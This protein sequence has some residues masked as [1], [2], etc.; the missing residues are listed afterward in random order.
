MQRTEKRHKE[1]NLDTRIVPR[2][3]LKP[4]LTGPLS[5]GSLLINIRLR[6]K[7]RRRRAHMGKSPGVATL[8]RQ[9]AS[10]RSE[11][12]KRRGDAKAVVYD[13]ET[14]RLG[15]PSHLPPPKNWGISYCESKITRCPAE[16]I[17]GGHEV[18]NEVRSWRPWMVSS[19]LRTNGCG[20][21]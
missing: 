12:T 8:F 10:A 16:I 15:P 7:S 9:K 11:N 14:S 2:R 19:S 4:R 5:R 6:K 3:S 1:I 13:W 21:V 20:G 18:F 17:Q